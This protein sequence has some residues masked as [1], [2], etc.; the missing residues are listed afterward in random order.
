[1][2]T[3]YVYYGG[4]II[5]I[6]EAEKDWALKELYAV[7][8]RN[9]HREVSDKT[10]QLI[11]R[12]GFRWDPLSDLGYLTFQPYAAFM[13]EATKEYIWNNVQQF[14]S[15]NDIPL[16]RIAGG[17]LYSLDNPLI[18]RHVQL[19]ENVGMYGND[20]LRVSGNKVLRFSG[21]SNKLSLLKQVDF[22]DKTLPFGIFEISDSY[23]YEQDANISLLARNR[24]FHLP[25]LHIINKDIKGGLDVILKGHQQMD[26][27]MRKYHLD[28]IMLFTTTRR[29]FEENRRFINSICK[30]CK[31]PPV[32][33]ITEEDTCENGIVFDVEYKAQMSNGSL[34]EIGTFQID[35]GTTG[36]SYD[37]KYNEIPVVTVHAVFFASSIERTIFTF[38]DLA[39]NK[40]RLPEWLAPVQCRIIPIDDSFMG[41]SMSICN[42]LS[43]QLRVEIDD[44][45]MQ[46]QKKLE[47]AKL[48]KAQYIL[49]IGK[50]TELYDYEKGLFT[51]ISMAN[52]YT[53]LPKEL[54][55]KN[56]FSP[57]VLSSNVF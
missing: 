40:D 28:Y 20:L 42:A 1:M 43:S 32:I 54:Y 46:I 53:T 48:I 23:R 41:L 5:P 45:E 27:D 29:F 37:I 44:R 8:F 49:K 18:S 16:H 17:D 26:K 36:F 9:E 13:E 25:E 52:F 11:E 56:S 31:H 50:M 15:N 2:S 19:A 6:N 34:L 22:N 4:E 24:F 12:M 35:E 38:C 57:H 7:E 21:C 33:N 14:C 51:S 10:K 55:Y 3:I 47:D 39:T 30:D